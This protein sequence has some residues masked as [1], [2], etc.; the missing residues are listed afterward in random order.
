[1]NDYYQQAPELY[2]ETARGIPGDVAFYRDLAVASGGPVVELGVGTGR[3]AI[4]TAAAGVEVIGIDTSPEMLVVARARAEAAGIASRLRLV[5]GDMRSFTVEQP[6]PLVTIPFRA[7]LHNLHDA[8]QEATLAACHRALQPGGRLALNVFNPDLG[9]I[10]RWAGRS[11]HHY[12]PFDAAG[13]VQAHH[14]FGPA[15]TV[16]SRLRWREVTVRRRGTLTLRYV[17]REEMEALLIRAG[18]TVEALY[19]DCQG[20]AFAE[21]STELVWL[22]KR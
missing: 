6:V 12:E 3:I 4:P 10:A 14:D 13:R 7:F 1:M 22:A 5:Q 8:D 21:A 18:F 2:D 19:G 15:R 17:R 16:T 9:I 11:A 20:G